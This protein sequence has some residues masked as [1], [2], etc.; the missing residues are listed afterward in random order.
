MVYF[1]LH[2]AFDEAV[3]AVRVRFILLPNRLTKALVYIYDSTQQTKLGRLG[4]S[5][6]INGGTTLARRTSGQFVGSRRRL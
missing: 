4:G 5:L 1:T 6:S 2:T 3:A